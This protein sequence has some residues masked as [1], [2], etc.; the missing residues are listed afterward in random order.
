MAEAAEIKVE[1][2]DKE[3]RIQIEKIKLEASLHANH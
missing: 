1:F 2:L 3:T